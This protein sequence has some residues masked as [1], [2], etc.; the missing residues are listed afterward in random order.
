M[1]AIIYTIDDEDDWTEPGRDPEGEPEHRRIGRRRLPAPQQRKA[2]A[3]PRIRSAFKTKHLNVWCAASVAGINMADWARA[4]DPSLSIEQF[5]GQ[6]AIFSLDF[7]SKLDICDFVKLFT[8]QIAGQTHYYAFARHYIPEDTV[9][10]ARAN[11]LAYRKWI[12]EGHL[13]ATEGAE[14]DFDEIRADVSEDRSRFQVTEVVYDPWRATQL[15]HQLAKDG[16]TVVE[17]GQTAKN[18]ASAF[19]ELLTALKAG[20]FHHD[21]DP[22]LAW[23]AGNVVAKSVAKGVTMPSKEKPD[24]KIDGIVAICMAIARAV[25]TEAEQ[26]PEYRLFV[27]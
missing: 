8:R 10:E 9:E 2:I 25:A 27:L 17:I 15:A 21:G 4:A 24:Q 19:D 26:P 12:A 14:I 1:F 5:N 16:A 6:P 22:V 3:N 7:A 23:M 11:Q 20:R 13:T 18:M